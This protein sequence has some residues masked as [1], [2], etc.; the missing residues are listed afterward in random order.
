MAQ[1][2]MFSKEVVE[3]EWFTD[4]PATTQMLYIHLSMD[5]DDDGFVTNTKMAMVNSHASKDDLA[6]L[7]AKNYVIKVENG[8]YLIKHWRQNNYIR[9][10][11]YKK[12][13]Y[14]DRLENFTVKSDGSYTL[15][16]PGE[17]ER[18]AIELFDAEDLEKVDNAREARKQARKEGSL[19]YSFDYKIRNAFEGKKC[20]ICGVEMHACNDY[21]MPTIQ[22]NTPISLGG[23]HEIGN[24]SVICRHCNTSIRNSKITGDLNNAEVKEE[25]ERICKANDAEKEPWLRDGIPSIGKD[26]LGKYRLEEVSKD[27]ELGKSNSN[28]LSLSSNEEKKEDLDSYDIEEVDDD[29][30]F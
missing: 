15:A 22:H 5:A 30:P 9:S 7:F 20:P 16:K 6:I 10:D 11:R 19:P 21:S 2:R 13:D 17:N 14:A 25:W 18:P 23:K 24:I 1:R 3:T 29:A 4:M 28:S 8:L 27:K 12:S 26:R